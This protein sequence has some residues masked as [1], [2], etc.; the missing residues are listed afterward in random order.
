MIEGVFQ[1]KGI[2]LLPFDEQTEAA[3]QGFLENEPIRA[4]MSGTRK[5]RSLQQNKWIHKIFEITSENTDDLEWN[6][7]EKTKRKVKMA[8]QFFKDDVTVVDNRVYFEFRSF[9]FDKMEQMEANIRYEEAKNIC[10]MKMGV[11][12]EVLEAEAKKRSRLNK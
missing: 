5:K 4:K 10:A 6:T 9:A 1:R 11:D 3:V 2:I 12:P 8:M 7:P